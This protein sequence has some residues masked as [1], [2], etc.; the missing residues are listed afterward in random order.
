MMNEKRNINEYLFYEFGFDIEDDENKISENYP[1]KLNSIGDF[2]INKEKIKVYEFTDNGR[3]NVVLHG[4]SLSTFEAQGMRLDDLYFQKLGSWWIGKSNPID[5]NTSKMGY[6]NIPSLSIRRQ[7]IEKLT[8]KVPS[9][10]KPAVLT[11]LYLIDNQQYLGL[12][13]TENNKYIVGTEFMDKID[14]FNDISSW[15]LLSWGIGKLIH[16]GILK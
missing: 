14:K 3:K 10:E 6:D 4:K 1:Y 8:L 11:G 12:F 2:E 7:E 15:R 5:L 9:S 13:K 16:A